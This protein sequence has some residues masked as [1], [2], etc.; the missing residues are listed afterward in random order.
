MRGAPGRRLIRYLWIV[1]LAAVVLAVGVYTALQIEPHTNPSGNASSDPNERCA[2]SPCGAPNGFEVDVT[3]VQAQGD[4]IALTVVFRNHTQPQLFEAV[5]YRHTS[6]ADFRLR[7]GGHELS[8]TFNA[9]C[10]DWPELDVNRGATS[11]PRQLCFAVT[12]S[13]KAVLVW[14]PDLGVI[15]KPVSIPLS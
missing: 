15:P 1:P 5:S 13:D 10:P 12:S 7:S 14:N 8:P 2:P 4:H 11:G 9:Q 6:P 3:A